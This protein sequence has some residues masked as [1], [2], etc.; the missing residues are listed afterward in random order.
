ME[1]GGPEPRLAAAR[2]AVPPGGGAFALPRLAMG[3]F[4]V[5]QPDHRFSVGSDR[6]KLIPLTAGQGWLLPAGATGFCEYDAP[7]DFLT[8]EISDDLMLDVGIDRRFDF[9]PSIGTLDP[10]L[11]QLARAAG[12]DGGQSSLYAETMQLAFAAHLAKILT[13]AQPAG[14]RVLE[15]R[16]L[17]RVLDHIHANLSSSL[18]LEDMASEAAMSRFHF[19]RAFTK[20]VGMSPLQYVIGERIRIAKVLLRTTRL[21]VAAIALRAGY[22]DTSRFGQHF[23]RHVGTTPAAFRRES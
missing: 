14:S 20:A 23:R 22:E 18:T 4:E 3:L 12:S 16:R 13:P 6:R 7:L 11:V 19:V 17:R 5:D 21:P 10:L 9:T 8:V 15:D 2:H 1:H